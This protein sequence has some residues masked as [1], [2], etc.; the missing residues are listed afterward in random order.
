VTEA[1]AEAVT[2]ASPTEASPTKASL[3]EPMPERRWALV[4]HTADRPGAI[5]AIT[6]VFSSRG[7]NFDS[8]AGSAPTPNQATVIGLYRT[9]E[10]RS[11]QLV[12]T[13]GRLEVV[14]S[15]TVRPAEDP[16]VRA[17][18]IM[19]VPNGD[20]LVPPPA[21]SATWTGDGTPERPLLVTGSLRAVEKIAAQA[22][23]AQGTA[24]VVV[25]AL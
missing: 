14:D 19:E 13:V 3:T 2:E 6:G 20:T 5:T 10:R 17:V 24:V 1:S 22:H 16:S 12:R 23:R 25:L 9:S 7:V 18:G 21:T 8:I 15:V 4:A 11:A